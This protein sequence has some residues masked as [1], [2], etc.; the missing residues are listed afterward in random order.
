MS[1]LK[2]HQCFKTVKCELVLDPETNRKRFLALP[3]QGVPTNL[4]IEGDKSIRAQYD[5]GTIFIAS[6]ITV[7]KKKIGRL[8]LRAQH[9][10]LTPVEDLKLDIHK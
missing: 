3:N 5:V 2:L 10:S 1:E 7:H 4:F 8:Y 6:Q 9:Q